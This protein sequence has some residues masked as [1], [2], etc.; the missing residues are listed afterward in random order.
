[1]TRVAAHGSRI[2]DATTRPPRNHA[3][4]ITL[5]TRC[6]P[7]HGKIAG[8]RTLRATPANHGTR[9]PVHQARRPGIPPPANNR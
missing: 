7:I 3:D 9:C 2:A 4:Q 8:R 1:M 5:I 6:R